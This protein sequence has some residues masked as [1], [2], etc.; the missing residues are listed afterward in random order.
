MEF[1]YW[2]INYEKLKNLISHWLYENK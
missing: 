2:I 1:V